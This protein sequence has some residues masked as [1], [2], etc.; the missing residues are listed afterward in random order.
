[1]TRKFLQNLGIESGLIDSI[2]DAH[3]EGINRE[4]EKATT[5]NKKLADQLIELQT[6]LEKSKTQ[7]DKNENSFKAK[8]ETEQERYK[9]AKTELEKLQTEVKSTKIDNLVKTLLGTE[10]ETHG[11]MHPAAIDKALK[12]YD[13]SLV[14]LDNTGNIENSSELLAHFAKDWGD[15]FAKGQPQ[16]IPQATPPQGANQ[17]TDYAGMLQTARKENKQLEA[18]RIKTEAAQNGVMLL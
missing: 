5:E 9:E 2:M 11:K 10:T 18:I 7:Q 17:A 6:E 16:G 14:K 13:R 12:L 3:G 8:Y 15:F 1:M 4:K